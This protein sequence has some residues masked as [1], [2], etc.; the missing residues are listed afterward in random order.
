MA[1]NVFVDP[2]INLF[3]NQKY[4]IVFWLGSVASW[5]LWRKK[6]IPGSTR[7]TLALLGAF[8]LIVFLFVALNSRLF[9]ISRYYLAFA[10]SMTMIAAY[11]L[12]TLWEQRDGRRFW[13]RCSSLARWVY[14]FLGLM[15]EN[16]NFR[17]GERELASWVA[18]HPGQVIHTDPDTKSRSD[19]FIQFLQA[20]AN[21]VVI[22]TPAPGALVFVSPDNVRR[23]METSRCR[24]YFDGF[25]RD[26]SSREVRRI[27]A[28]G[29][30][31][32]QAGATA[33]SGSPPS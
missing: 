15:L 3:V 1:I 9:L 32:F 11:W 6:D 4:G 20:N 29:E 14:V 16:I 21:A 31:Y 8:G 30:I 10:W 17:F 13:Q 27:R 28:I 24:A 7:R 23:C 2:V 33:G 19:Y 25:R 22:G 12:A 5:Q 26:D 18:S